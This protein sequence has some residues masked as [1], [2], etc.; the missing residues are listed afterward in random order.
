MNLA[1]LRQFKPQIL[2]IAA[3]YGV[4]NIRVFGS[5]ARGDA[6]KN[7]DVDFAIHW[8]HPSFDNYLNLK[9]SLH[10]L[11]GCEVDLVEI[12]NVRNPLR[13]KYMLEDVTDL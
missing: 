11:L 13:R 10:N 7:S 9:T 2:T 1:E 12:E 5:V 8:A 4:S 3:E 6:D